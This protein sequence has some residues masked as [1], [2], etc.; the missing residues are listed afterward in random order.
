MTMRYMFFQSIY[1]LI[2]CLFLLF[3]SL[4]IAGTLDPGDWTKFLE[5]K[6]KFSNR[7]AIMIS[8]EIRSG[9][10][11]FNSGMLT[12]SKEHIK[13]YFHGNDTR[14]VID[15]LLENMMTPI[16]LIGGL[17]LFIHIYVECHRF[18]A[19]YR[20]WDGSAWSYRPYLGDTAICQLYSKHPIFHRETGNQVICFSQCTRELS[21]VFI[22]NRSD[23]K[24]FGLYNRDAL[25]PFL[26]QEMGKYEINR[27]VK[28]YSEFAH[29]KYRYK[30]RLRHDEAMVHPFPDIDTF[31]F[32]NYAV[33][34]DEA[35]KRNIFY[36]D[37]FFHGFSAQDSVDFG[38]ADDMDLVMDRL[39]E[40]LVNL[41]SMS[42]DGY[43][44]TI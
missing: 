40:L 10:I 16:A 33:N 34:P 4:R 22:A 21:N 30:I 36:P 2:V 24:A 38:Y 41:S 26:Q 15:T 20:R 14:T 23:W 7:T 5:P 13:R 31:N 17:D 6:Y 8:G 28:E 42:M 29:K 3:V 9:N 27:L 32:F 19:S 11:S 37:Y 44:S 12:D 25:E 35:N 43:Q 1:V 18:N 39:Q